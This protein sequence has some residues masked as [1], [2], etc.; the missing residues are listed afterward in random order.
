MALDR[1]RIYRCPTCGSELDEN[2]ETLGC[3]SCRINYPCGAGYVDF[4]HDENEGPSTPLEQYF[5]ELV[6]PLYENYYFPFLYRLGTLPAFDSPATHTEEMVERTMTQEAT[7]LDV[8]CGTGLLSRK[9]A[10]VNRRVIGLDRSLGMI[11][12]SVQNRPREQR[13]TLDYCRAD[14][15]QLPFDD[16]TFQAVTCTGAFYLFPELK[17]VFREIRRVLKPGG[18]LAGMTIVKK[19][20]LG[21]DVTDWVL[22][23]YRRIGS[24]RVHETDSFRQR[25]LDSGYEGFQYNRYGCV[26]LFNVASR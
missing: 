26:M 9:L 21:T 25:L 19:G 8:A 4:L 17:P 24:F 13:E 12:Q 3:D 22:R 6:P 1:R 16:S 2:T 18:H 10:E 5:F 15:Y 23:Q 7:V 11:R 14:A 20:I